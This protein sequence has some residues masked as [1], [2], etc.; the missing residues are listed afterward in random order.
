MPPELE[1][2]TEEALS[3]PAPSRAELAQRLLESLEDPAVEIDRSWA[4]EAERR[5]R[6]L[7]E[8]TVQRLPGEEVIR[9]I[10]ARIG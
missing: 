3:L 5:C 2:L 1:R 9:E 10:R 7:D 8:G 6:E 4:I